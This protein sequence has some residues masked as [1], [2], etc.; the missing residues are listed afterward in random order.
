MQQKASEQSPKKSTAEVNRDTR[1]P[2]VAPELRREAEL[3][4]LTAE[5]FFTFSDES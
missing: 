4:K 1:K 5:V 3:T 2:F